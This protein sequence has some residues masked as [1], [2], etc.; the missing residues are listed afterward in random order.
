MQAVVV[1]GV[2]FDRDGLRK[3]SKNAVVD[4]LVAHSDECDCAR[5]TDFENRVKLFELVIRVIE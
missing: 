5:G 3:S 1:V 2:E 4:L